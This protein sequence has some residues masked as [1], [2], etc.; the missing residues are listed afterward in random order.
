MRSSYKTLTL[1]H[2]LYVG[3]IVLDFGK[4]VVRAQNAIL[5]ATQQDFYCS[6]FSPILVEGYARL[7][8]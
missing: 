3:A 8:K 4:D 2:K 5:G 7:I 1:L 6:W